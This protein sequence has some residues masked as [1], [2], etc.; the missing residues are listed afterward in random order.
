MF[1]FS[2][3]ANVII[4]IINTTT[5]VMSKRAGKLLGN[6]KVDRKIILKLILEKY[7]VRALTVYSTASG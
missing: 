4:I 3:T 1:W 5:I 7:V 6:L 2:S